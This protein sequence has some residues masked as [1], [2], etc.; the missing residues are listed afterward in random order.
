MYDV[1]TSHLMDKSLALG[2][3]LNRIHHRFNT[4][5]TAPHP[6]MYNRGIFIPDVNT[7]GGFRTLDT[8]SDVLAIYQEPVRFFRPL[9]SSLIP[10]SSHLTFS[11]EPGLYRHPWRRNCKVGYQS[12]LFQPKTFSIQPAQT[13]FHNTPAYDWAGSAICR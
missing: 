1:W 5:V 11:T 2:K 8:F 10:L 13:E 6:G 7:S 9:P 12:P 3:L 4:Q